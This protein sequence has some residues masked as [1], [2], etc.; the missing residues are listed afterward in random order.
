MTEKIT[1]AREERCETCKFWERIPK[2]RE[3]RGDC[4]RNAP[5]PI[6]TYSVDSRTMMPP[7]TL[8]TRW[9]GEWKKK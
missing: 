3:N 7:R 8:P 6:D 4:N 9:C 5:S 1:A 2:D